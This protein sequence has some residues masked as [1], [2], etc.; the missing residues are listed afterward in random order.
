M[1]TLNEKIS[2]LGDYINR[3]QKHR[4]YISCAMAKP[5]KIK[6]NQDPPPS[7]ELIL[8]LDVE[9]WNSSKMLAELKRQSINIDNVNFDFVC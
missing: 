5:P 1:M 7:R 6:Y 4:E 9:L 2:Y 8:K 3:I